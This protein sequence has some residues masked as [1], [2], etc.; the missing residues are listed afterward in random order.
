MKNEINIIRN[1]LYEEYK[2]LWI[3]KYYNLNYD[4]FD[5]W[6]TNYYANEDCLRRLTNYDTLEYIKQNDPLYNKNIFKT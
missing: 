4:S 3:E 5:T 2:V 1:K 6:L